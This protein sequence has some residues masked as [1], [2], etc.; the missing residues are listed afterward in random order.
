MGILYKLRSS[1]IQHSKVDCIKKVSFKAFSSIVFTVY[2]IR[3]HFPRDNTSE[4]IF[5]DK[6]DAIISFFAE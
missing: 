5:I 6:S 3:E 1:A 2:S 4:S